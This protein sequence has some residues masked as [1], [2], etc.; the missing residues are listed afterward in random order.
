MIVQCYIS[1]DPT[2]TLLAAQEF[3][4]DHGVSF[5]AFAAANIRGKTTENAD[6]SGLRRSWDYSITESS[7]F[8]L[9]ANIYKKFNLLNAGTSASALTPYRTK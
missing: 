2:N 6:F 9:K 3:E 8:Y 5:I 1:Y 4:E 7:K